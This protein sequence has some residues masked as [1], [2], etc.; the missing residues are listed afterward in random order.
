M[1]HELHLTVVGLKALAVTGVVSVGIGA[2][3]SGALGA[4]SAA[5]GAGLVGANHAA[6]A[7]STG[8]SR[9]LRPRVMA[10]GYAMFGLRML[11]MFFAFAVLASI[12]WVHPVHLATAFCA[13][14]VA[15]LGTECWSYMRTSYVP[16]WRLR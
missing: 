15:V 7:L 1:R 3:V 12:A 6:A 4:A 16:S 10:V 8:W 9:E 14:L 5:L 13:G 2:A 11:A